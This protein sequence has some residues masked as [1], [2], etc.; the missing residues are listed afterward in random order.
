[1]SVPDSEFQAL[2]MAVQDKTATAAQEQRLAE[3]LRAEPL[4]RAE[5]VRQ[6][7]L[8][9]LLRF[10][11]GA[12]VNTTAPRVPERKIIP[13]PLARIAAIAALL[14]IAAMVA[15]L[16]WPQ[17][18]IEVEVLA[19]SGGAE[20]NFFPGSRARRENLKLVR[21]ELQVRLASGVVLDVAGPVEMGLVDAMHVRVLSG[22]VTAD[23][24]DR[25]K[26]FVIDTPQARVVDL[27]TRFGVDAS[28]AAHTDV[29]VFQGKVDVFEP[30]H[31]G[32]PSPQIASL[33]EG[34]AVQVSADGGRKR[35]VCVFTT[36]DSGDW[37][38]RP[39]TGALITGID[40]ST[41][42]ARSNRFYR[43]GVGTLTA[44]TS[45]RQT[46]PLSWTTLDGSPLP[47]WLEGGDWVETGASE[48]ETAR[49]LRVTLARPA[50]LFVLQDVRRAPPAWLREKFTDTGM[51][52]LLERSS[53]K[54]SGEA[55]SPQPFTVWSMKVSQP[56]T[57]TL[58]PSFDPGQA[59]KGRRYRVAAKA[60]P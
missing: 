58:G 12:A 30:Q 45:L 34:E 48:D 54:A 52:L 28:Y 25:G 40:D 44:G 24:G 22:R 7:R 46:H 49:E 38:R 27:G 53:S 47:D 4:L 11:A 5:Y 56:G 33:K 9:A 55:K 43:V 10:T 18:G 20:A 8:N 41:A 51:R 3:L 21:G 36:G 17:R 37:S 19:A 39:Q 13:F 42:G 1:M 2:V 15:A 50:M 6:M 60:L 31:G 32:Q 59:A 26:G 35:V 57:V 23:V 29:V 16:W 14:L